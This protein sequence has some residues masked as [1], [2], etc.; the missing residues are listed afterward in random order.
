MRGQVWPCRDGSELAF[1][2]WSS[3]RIGIDF[4]SLVIPTWS[5]MMFFLFEKKKC[6]NLKNKKAAMALQN[7]VFYTEVWSCTKPM[8][9]HKKLHLL[10]MSK[11][12]HKGVINIPFTERYIIYGRCAPI[13]FVLKLKKKTTI[14]KS[15]SKSCIANNLNNWKL[16]APNYSGIRTAPPRPHTRKVNNSS[17]NV[18]ANIHW[19]DN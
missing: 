6:E 16:N 12:D 7:Y 10:K 2:H 13:H 3:T 9:L 11:S 19:I 1:E 4:T 17:I 5:C 18:N 14:S 15:H 8:S